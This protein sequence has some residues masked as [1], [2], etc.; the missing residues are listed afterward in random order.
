MLYARIAE[1]GVDQHQQLVTD[2]SK[3]VFLG[4]AFSLTYVVHEVLAQFL[5][6][7]ANHQRRLHF[8]LTVASG[9]FGGT[10]SCHQIAER[11]TEYLH[12]AELLYV[13]T[14]VVLHQ[15]LDT[16]FDAFH[17]AFPILDQGDFLHSVNTKGASLLILNAVCMVA[18]TLCEDVL[19]TSLGD[20]DRYEARSLFYQQAK[21]L[22]DAD[23][24]P[25]KVNNVIGVFLMSFWWSKP[26]DQ[27]D[28]WHW[29][30]IAASLAQSMGMH[31]S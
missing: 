16:Y 10:L 20:K 30:G 27:K 19:L 31:R 22:Y 25:N 18:V 9:G 17:P 13:P 11:Q 12:N 4:E 15:L 14:P 6:T 5:A 7:S 23:L 3:S 2:A 21:A 1:E 8:P 26:D 28:S 29:L 24:E